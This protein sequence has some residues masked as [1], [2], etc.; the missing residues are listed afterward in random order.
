MHSRLY[1]RER[2]IY[3]VPTFCQFRS[4]S[5]RDFDFVAISDTIQISFKRLQVVGRIME[6]DPQSETVNFTVANLAVSSSPTLSNTLTIYHSTIAQVSPQEHN[7]H[8]K[9]PFRHQ[10]DTSKNQSHLTDRRPYSRYRCD[11]GLALPNLSTSSLNRSRTANS[12]IRSL[13]ST[14]PDRL[15]VFLE[16]T[17][18]CWD[19]WTDFDLA[20]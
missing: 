17:T 16:T 1:G 10:C 2:I 14:D 5:A 13:M 4:F 7:Q 19:K 11:S 3:H 9:L 15:L 8:V 12:L 20:L 6:K 18:G